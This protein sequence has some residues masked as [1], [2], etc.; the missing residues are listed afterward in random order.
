MTV[1]RSIHTV[2]VGISMIWLLSACG[3]KLEESEFDSGTSDDLSQT[4]D[5][6]F[7]D[8]ESDNLAVRDSADDAAI[9]ESDSS[10][11]PDTE[12]ETDTETD[13]EGFVFIDTDTVPVATLRC[14]PLLFSPTP[15]GFSLN[16]VLENGDPKKLRLQVKTEGDTNW[17]PPMNPFYTDGIGMLDTAIFQ[18]TDLSPASAY[19]YRLLYRRTTF[20]DAFQL[21]SEGTLTTIEPPGRSFSFAMLSD[22]H[23]G[24]D[25]S[26]S[27]Q[28]VPEWCREVASQISVHGPRFTIHL[29]DVLDFHQ[30]GFNVPSPS[31][32][33]TKQAYLSYRNLLETMPATMFHFSTIGNWDGESGCFTD[34]EI[35]R[36]RDARLVYMPNPN[37][38]TVGYNGSDFQDY[39]AFNW[40]DAMFIVLNVQSYTMTEHL[41]STFSEGS[42]DDWTLGQ[43]QLNWL[44]QTLS[45]A[46]AKWRFVFIHHTVGGAAATEENSIYGRGGG[47]A[48]YVGEQAV[49]HQ[50]MID[51]DVQILFYGHDHVF[52][53]MVVDGIHY[54]SPGSAGAPWLFTETTTGYQNY[55]AEPGWALVNVSPDDVHVQ[56][57]NLNEDVVYEYGL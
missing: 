13:S 24:S 19:Q 12:T 45:D 25:M 50:L 43:S 16:A 42:A 26:Y 57:I 27:N 41:L 39:Y 15:T 56:F 31:S 20:D 51:H 47:Q 34:E 1:S 3:P 53:D 5:V 9:V 33:L 7:A 46:S 29:G 55:I 11:A 23:I 4:D 49:I 22:T 44:E 8:S 48:A 2:S 10:I 37:A 6:V 36:S 14:A 30:Y 38:Q 54:S 18:A 32:L 52:T 35:L 28:G 17:N 40:G 21:L